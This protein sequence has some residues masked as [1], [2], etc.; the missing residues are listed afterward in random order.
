MVANIWQQDHGGNNAIEIWQN[1]IKALRQYLRG[2]A[3]YSAGI[4]KKEKKQVANKIDEIDKKAETISL[5]P[6]EVALKYYLNERLAHL[7]REEE[8]K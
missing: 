4:L 2:W 6:N 5:S 7:M 8:L 1:K 3:K